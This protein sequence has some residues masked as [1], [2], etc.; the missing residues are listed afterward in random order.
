MLAAADLETLFVAESVTMGGEDS[1]WPLCN[2]KEGM[3]GAFCACLRDSRSGTCS[4]VVLVVVVFVI[5]EGEGS[6]SFSS[7]GNKKFEPSP[8]SSSNVFCSFQ[9]TQSWLMY[10]LAAALRDELLLLTA[11]SCC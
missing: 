7:I 8:E 4:L 1:P 11:S 10:I 3:V 2:A 6:S 9:T 5:V